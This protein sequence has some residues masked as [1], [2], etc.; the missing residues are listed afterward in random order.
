M[1]AK[2]KTNIEFSKA[3]T[4]DA[5]ENG[6]LKLYADKDD[7]L[8]TVNSKGEVETLIGGSTLPLSIENGGTGQTTLGKPNEALTVNADGTGTEWKVPE[9]GMDNPMTTKGQIIYSG[10][11]GAPEALNP[12]ETS[13][14]I[15]FY[16]VFSHKP[17][18]LKPA[19]DL[20]YAFANEGDLI[21]GSNNWSEKSH[22][23]PAGGAGQVLRVT[24]D[25]GTLAEEKK[26]AWE[27]PPWMESPMTGEGDIIVGGEEGKPERLAPGTA[28]QVLA[29]NDDESAIV[30]KTPEKPGMENP[31]T[32]KTDLIIGGEGG[33]PERLGKGEAGQVLAINESSDGLEWK[34]PNPGFQNPMTTAGDMMIG[35]E[36]GTAERIGKGEAGQVLTMNGSGTGPEW[37]T[38]DPGFQNPMTDKADIMIGGESGVPERLGKGEA[39]QVLTINGSSDGLEWKTPEKGMKNPMTTAGDLITG[40]TDGAPTRLAPGAAGKV[41]AV[42]SAA[43]GLEWVTGMTNPMTTSADMITAGYNG[44]ARRLAAPRTDGTHLLHCYVDA[45]TPTIMWDTGIVV[46]ESWN[47]NSNFYRQYSDGFCIQGGIVDANATKITL[48]VSMVY[49]DYVC[50]LVPVSGTDTGENAVVENQITPL[51]QSYST[52]TLSSAIDRKRKWLVMGW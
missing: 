23:L 25:S 46:T 17:Y 13:D 42:N 45:L 9:K 15:L 20:I 49:T 34:T 31:M 38:P 19:I 4:P 3:D 30:W 39:G 27:N 29:I 2:F 44:V 6:C 1:G 33:A 43:T 8:K 14:Q 32:A 11:D 10:T 50:F 24:S 48:Y 16:N 5:A 7:T 51:R 37:K 28:G 40:G 41:L 21:V 12:P 36:G 18:W 52:I 26:I 47:Q 35:G 22:R